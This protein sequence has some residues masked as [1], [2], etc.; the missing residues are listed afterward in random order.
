MIVL[1]LEEGRSQATA[2]EVGLTL[3]GRN[4][5]NEKMNVSVSKQSYIGVFGVGLP[6]GNKDFIL[7]KFGESTRVN[8]SGD[9]SRFDGLEIDESFLGIDS[10]HVHLAGITAK[11]GF[12]CRILTR[13][14]RSFRSVHIRFFGG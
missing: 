14:R 5:K 3:H 10:A 12:I 9:I 8:I 4:E 7:P 2:F 1:E 6:N 13:G 11:E